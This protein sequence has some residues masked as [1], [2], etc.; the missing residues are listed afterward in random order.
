MWQKRWH[1]FYSRTLHIF[2]DLK[3][4]ISSIFI[5]S[6]FLL[7]RDVN[8]C[9][10]FIAIGCYNIW[11][12][13]SFKVWDYRGRWS[14]VTTTSLLFWNCFRNHHCLLP[15]GGGFCLLVQWVC[16][17]TISSTITSKLSFRFFFLAKFW[18]FFHNIIIPF[19]LTMMCIVVSIWAQSY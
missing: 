16:L 14:E 13:H 6:C 18:M 12:N 17:W 19:A 1:I 15:V 8:C 7:G 10:F 4:A 2:S 3:P 5:N 11:H 9:R